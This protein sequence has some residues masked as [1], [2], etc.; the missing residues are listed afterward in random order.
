MGQFLDDFLLTMPETQRKKLLELLELKQK[1]G[2]I[3]SEEQFRKELE[4]LL[5]QLETYNGTPTF[6]PVYQEGR[7]SSQAYNQNMESI[8]FDL[9]T[10]FDASN[11]IETL[12]SD[13]QQLSRSL[14]ADIRKKIYMLKSQVERYQLLIN[15]SDQFIEAIH[16]DF[17]VP[18]YTETD[19]ELLTLLR[20][21]RFGQPLTSL[22]NAENHGYALQLASMQTEDQL[23]TSYGRKL[24]KIEVRNRTGLEASNNHYPIE[25]AIDGSPDT[26]WAEA[27]IVDDVIQQDIEDLW[28]HDYHDYPKTGAICELEITLNGL[29]TVSEIQFV[30]YCSYPLEIVAIHGYEREDSGGKM[31]SL[32]SPNHPNIYQRSQKSTDRMVFQFPSVEIS[33]L[34]ILIRQENYEKENFIVSYD[35]LH[36]MEM[37]DRIASD[38]TL[39]PDFK[40]PGESIAEFDKKNEITGWQLYLKKLKEWAT[41]LRKE[42]IV[43]AAEKAMEIIKMGDY[44]N[45]LLLALRSINQKGEKQVV[46]DPRSPMLSQQWLA[47]NKLVYIY[48]AYDIRVY[49]RKYHRTSIYIS[50]PLPLNSNV[51]QI[52]LST[53]E[54]HHY[55][56]IGGQEIDPV[57]KQPTEQQVKI[58]DIEYY[59]TFKKNP[60]P[61]DW[62]P[63][64]PVEQK[65]VE[66]ELLLGDNVQGDYPEF[67]NMDLIIFEFR[68]PVVS[69]ETVTIRQNG[70]PMTPDMYIIS[71]DGKKVGIKRE[72]YS[73][74][75]IYTADYKPVDDAY[76]IR[77]DQQDIG[78]EPMPFMNKN[79]ELGERFEKADHNNSI[80][81]TYYPY[82]YRD[83][84]FQYNPAKERY[85]QDETKYTPQEIYYPII[86]RVNGEEFKNITDYTT[87]TYDP[88]RLKENGGKTFAHIGKKIIFGTPI[89]GPKI[90]NIVVDYHYIATEMRIKAI[91]RRNHAGYESITPSLYSY[92]I[93]CQSF[94]QEE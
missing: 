22:F 47:T 33:K 58:T 30:P 46:Q 70:Y 8:A 87:N 32:I 35:N 74:S 27:I 94:D 81:L 79:G 16:E 59:V 34:R 1:Q 4:T 52:S 37:W 25:N 31:Y 65:Y 77:I 82:L 66:G 6:S 92:Q 17:K 61:K 5:K 85:D 90:E 54:K 55:I 19:E 9:A 83:V 56:T 39:I 7:T 43:E 68:F 2:I 89:N 10:L 44:K 78:I 86:V 15:H 23:K 80:E 21:D 3:R 12:I 69:K 26:F 62:K 29:T 51:R 57:T 20:K 45:P 48:G 72:Y 88:E 41:I 49:G 38:S 24:A 28:S 53:K 73:P 11:Q 50:K 40:E 93:R 60:L 91:L 71:D 75:S 13:N 67:R 14:L 42:G 84:L 63:I 76:I 36:N 64:L 18:Q